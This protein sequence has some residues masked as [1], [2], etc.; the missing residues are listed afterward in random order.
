MKPQPLY[1]QE[2]YSH[3]F[4]IK[5]ELGKSVLKINKININR[6]YKMFK[7]GCADF[8]VPIGLSMQ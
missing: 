4:T 6:T 3:A 7:M 1:G 5:R 8:T 2:N